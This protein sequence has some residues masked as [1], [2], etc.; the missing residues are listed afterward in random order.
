MSKS[1]REIGRTGTIAY[2]LKGFPRLSETFIASEIYRVERTGLQLRLFV[3]KPRAEVTQHPVVEK[4]QSMLSYM[5]SV[6][7]LSQTW[8]SVWLIRNYPV[9]AIGM[10]RTCVRWPVGSARAFVLA[11]S[12]SFS[13]RKS[14]GFSLRGIFIRD[15]LLATALADRLR[16]TPEVRHLHAHFCHG[17]TTVA[18]LASCITGIPFSFTAHAKDIY[19]PSLNPAGLLGRKLRAARFAVTCTEANRRH[20]KNIEPGAD[21]HRLYHGLNVDFAELLTSNHRVGSQEHTKTRILAVGRLVPKKGFEVLVQAC[22]KLKDEGLSFELRIAG[23]DGEAGDAVRSAIARHQLQGSVT[24]LG[25]LSQQQLYHEY[26]A[27]TVFC[28][29]CRIARNGDRDGV[30]NVLVEAMACGLPVIS[31]LVSGIPEVVTHDV[32][33]VLV[34]PDN[35]DALALGL[36]RLA[37]DPSLR[38]RLGAAARVTVR[39]GFDGADSAAMLSSLFRSTLAEA[40]Y[41]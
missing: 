24:V 35:P 29:P 11:L 39:D 4:I 12:L 15:Y 20:L 5:P 16:Q 31:T 22:A 27:A 13:A 25:P 26:N 36:T 7:S 28:L 10:F 19:V 3:L 38:A 6:T 30:P 14:K 40:Q 23:E 32:N 34:A 41:A 17:A 8:L 18:M 37:V 21:V 2:V 1:P 33:G 9:F